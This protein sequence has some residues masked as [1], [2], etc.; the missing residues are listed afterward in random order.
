ME[1]IFEYK[2]EVRDYEC[3]AQGIVNNANYQHYMEH[4]RHRFIQTVNLDFMELTNAGIILV[5]AKAELQYKDSLR[6]NDEFVC[7]LNVEKEGIRYI[8]YEDIYRLSDNKLCTKGR[9]E[10]VAKIN[11]RLGIAESVDK[12]LF[13]AKKE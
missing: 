8:F 3:D 13:A 2:F 10:I 4:A 1:Y 5:V 12:A 7:R 9:F 11:G 6:S